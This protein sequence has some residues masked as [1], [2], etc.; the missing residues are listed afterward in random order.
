MEFVAENLTAVS[1]R[2]KSCYELVK[3]RISRLK[4]AEEIIKCENF[5]TEVFFFHF[6]LL[7]I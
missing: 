5:G 4:Q 1:E 6:A 7:N 3:S 2:R